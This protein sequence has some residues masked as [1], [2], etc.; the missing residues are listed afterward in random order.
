[1]MFGKTLE[2]LKKADNLTEDEILFMKNYYKKLPLDRSP[3][4]MNKICWAVEDVFDSMSFIPSEVFDYSVLKSNQIYEKS[5]AQQILSLYKDYK[6]DSAIVN[7]QIA[8]KS[9]NDE[10]GGVVD[11]DFLMEAFRENCYAICPNAFVLCDILV[12]LGYTNKISKN[13]VWYVCGDIILKNLLDKHNN[14]I[15]YPE[16]NVNGDIKCCG[17]TFSMKTIEVRW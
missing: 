14:L 4:V 12:D 17:S 10:D 7:K 5:I 15:S 11:K 13:L 8:R 2:Q 9:V 1:M 3:S 16:R 6:K